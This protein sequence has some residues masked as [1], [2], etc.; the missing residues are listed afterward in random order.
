MLAVVHPEP[1]DTVIIYSRVETTR[2]DAEKI[3][4]RAK[5]VIAEQVGHSQFDVLVVATL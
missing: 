1:G 4:D 3:R 5:A 2:D